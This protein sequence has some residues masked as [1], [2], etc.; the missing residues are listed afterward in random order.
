MLL[1]SSRPPRP[2]RRPVPTVRTTRSLT[3]ALD[4]LGLQHVPRLS[5]PVAMTVT[6]ASS[7]IVSSTTQPQMTSASSCASSWMR[8]EASGSVH[9]QLLFPVMLI[10]TEVVPT[11]E[12]S[13]SSGEEMARCAAST[14]LCS[15]EA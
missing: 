1:V 14:V 12:T 11:I 3:L 7:S 5:K 4:R 8:E 10:I 15:P 2:P 6:R 9:G 13:S